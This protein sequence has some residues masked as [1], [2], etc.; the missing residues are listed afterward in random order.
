MNNYDELKGLVHNVV[1]TNK[2]EVSALAEKVAEHCATLCTKE[3]FGYISP[4][5]EQ[6][7]ESC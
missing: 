2:E 5:N 6:Q 1:D 3:V 4:K 7:V